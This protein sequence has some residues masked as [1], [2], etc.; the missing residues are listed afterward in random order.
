MDELRLSSRFAFKQTT[1]TSVSILYNSFISPF[2]LPSS[3]HPSYVCRLPFLEQSVLPVYIFQTSFIMDTG[4][5]LSI[6][7]TLRKKCCI[8][9]CP[10]NCYNVTSILTFQDTVRYQFLWITFTLTL[11]SG[12]TYSLVLC[13][14]FGPHTW[15]S[16]SP[17]LLPLDNFLRGDT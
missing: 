15:P 12:K 10:V 7:C 17:D 6:P 8:N 2:F 13:T 11:T 5:I 9:V 3:L 16:R 4:F 1:S 14:R